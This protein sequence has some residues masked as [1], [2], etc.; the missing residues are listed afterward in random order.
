MRLEIRPHTN[1]WYNCLDVLILTLAQHW[2]CEHRM[3]FA[4]AWRFK[5]EPHRLE[6]GAL[7]TGPLEDGS[8]FPW[9]DVLDVRELVE[10]RNLEELL[11][12]YHG[13][14]ISS[15]ELSSLS[16]AQSLVAA[17]L[18]AGYPVALGVDAFFCHWSAA[19]RK[20]HLDHYCLAIGMDTDGLLIIDPYLTLE[21]QRF[22]FAEYEPTLRDALTFRHAPAATERPDWR[23]VAGAAAERMLGAQPGRPSPLQQ[24]R[25]LARDLGQHLDFHEEVARHV[26]PFASLVEHRH[27]TLLD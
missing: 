14:S 21:P 18:A 10:R 16:A 6:T 11:R 1:P 19:F 20:Y 4:E 7:E 12:R 24:M 13:L 27:L 8:S 17:E 2:R 3:M 15:H 25:A 22:S 5:Y 23:E 9:R 26:D